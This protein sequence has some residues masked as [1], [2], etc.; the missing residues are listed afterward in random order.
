MSRQPLL[1]A[2][3]L[4]CAATPAVAQNQSQGY[5]FL[6]A[7]RDGK[8]NDVIAM[9]D[10]PGASVINARDI[11]TGEGALHIVIKRGDTTYLRYLLQKGADPN[12]R[13]GEGVTPMLMAVTLGQTDMIPILAAARANVNLGNSAGETPLIRAVQRRDLSE[14]RELIKAGADPDQADRLAGLSARDYATRDTRNQVIAKEL[15]LTPKKA[16]KAVSG[17][18]L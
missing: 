2:L 9:L 17:P 11:T 15:A 5:K 10:K 13:D 1:F 14:V 7:V 18:R 4:A 16:S 6:S 12:L 8:G 3:L